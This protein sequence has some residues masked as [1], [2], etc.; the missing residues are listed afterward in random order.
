MTYGRVHAELATTA[1]AAFVESLGLLLA[2]VQWTAADL[3][4]AMGVSPQWAYKLVTNRRQGSTLGSIDAVCAAFLKATPPLVVAPADLLDPD[5]LRGKLGVTRPITPT[6]KTASAPI[7][8]ESLHGAQL[9]DTVSQL[10]SE[11]AHI[12]S[13]LFDIYTALGRHFKTGH[14]GGSRAQGSVVPAAGNKT[15]PGRRHRG[16]GA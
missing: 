11:H 4:A 6:H 8:L 14:A 10:Q 12:T 9:A 3:G 2:H 15:R 1:I 5:R 13:A 7:P 16:S